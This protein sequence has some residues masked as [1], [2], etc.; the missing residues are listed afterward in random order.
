MLKNLSIL[1]TCVCGLL[2][3]SC[4]RVREGNDAVLEPDPYFKTILDRAVQFTDSNRNTAGYRFIDS[5]YMANADKATV[6]DKFFYYNFYFTSYHRSGNQQVALLYA[7]SMI[8]EANKKGR[9]NN[10]MLAEANYAKGDAYFAMYQ[11]EEAYYYTYLAKTQVRHNVDSCGISD[12]NYRLGMILYK[13][14]RYAEAAK[15]FKESYSQSNVCRDVFLYFYRRQELLD[16]IGI[17]Y[18]KLKKPDSALHYFQLAVKHVESGVNNYPEKSH[19]VFQIATGVIYGNMGD[20]YRDLK[21][22]D[23]A[24]AL[25]KRSIHINS[26]IYSD[27]TDAQFTRIKLTKIYLD[28][29]DLQQARQL[30]DYIDTIQSKKPNRDANVDR[31]W[32]NLMWQYYEARHEPAIAFSFLKN[33]TQLKDSLNS[34]TQSFIQTDVS[35]RFK[36]MDKE[37]ELLLLEKNNN[38]TQNYLVLAVMAA[39]LVLVILIQMLANWRKS[40]KNVSVLTSLNNHIKS[41]KQ[42]L[43]HTNNE[44][45]RILRVVAHDVRNPITAISALSEFLQLDATNLTAE[46]LEYITL[47]NEA[48]N[49][50]LT[51]TKEILDAANSKETD[52]LTK[53]WVDINTLLNN[54]ISL[55]R[56]KAADKGQELKLT[57]P[58]ESIAIYADKEKIWR[59]INN[60]VV[61][62]VKFSNHLDVIEI[63]ASK[64]DEVLTIAVKD[65]GIGIPDK[66]KDKVFEM[67]TEAKRSG[68]AGEKSFGLGLSIS[69]KIIRDHGGVIIF[70]STEGK[71]TTFFITLPAN[72]PII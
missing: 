45:D 4:Q 23:S 71:G 16:N 47:I 17:C 41:Q 21:Q 56:F 40:K 6:V 18:I 22:L 68:T 29:N 9:L 37:Y 49:N 48:C 43:E 5:A 54:S 11:Y 2:I 27:F 55:L 31:Q 32:N 52:L 1:I 38:L 58:E 62:A 60:L 72:K 13:Q 61:N 46:Q 39:I 69:Q 28:K 35:E 64:K 12:Y 66:Y 50:A 51:L 59:V 44:K 30:L 42:T 57:L 26:S 25:Y 14:V 20:A 15:S 24:E 3:A 36:N 33:Y 10:K 34:F 7:D 67:F 53:E 19:T 63:S 8:I 65:N 70:D